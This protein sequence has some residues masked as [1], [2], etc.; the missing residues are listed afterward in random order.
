MDGEE[1][2]CA[3]ALDFLPT[4]DVWL[5]N[6]ERKRGSFRLPTRTDYFYPDYVA[7]LSDS[8]LLAL[9]YKGQ[10]WLDSDDTKEKRRLGE[11]WA[12]GSGN[13]FLLVGHNDYGHELQRIGRPAHRL[14]G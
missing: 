1:A 13:V 14:Y 2:E 8:R 3:R 7:R 10:G 4:V 11:L 6:V 9:E 12:R 5:R